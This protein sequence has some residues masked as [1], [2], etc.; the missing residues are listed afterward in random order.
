[1]YVHVHTQFVIPRQ[2]ELT[3]VVSMKFVIIPLCGLLISIPPII[4]CNCQ[5]Q[6]V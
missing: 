1:M 5:L 6:D 4:D 3:R 2:H